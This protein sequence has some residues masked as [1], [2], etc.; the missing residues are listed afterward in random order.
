MLILNLQSAAMCIICHNRIPG[1][2]TVGLQI[3][4]AGWAGDFKR[5]LGKF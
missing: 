1:Q 5:L 4:V 2:F 3:V